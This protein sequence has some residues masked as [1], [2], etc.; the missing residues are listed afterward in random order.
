[1][2]TRACHSDRR[3]LDHQRCH[4]GRTHGQSQHEHQRDERPDT[5]RVEIAQT[6]SAHCHTVSVNASHSPT[7]PY[8]STTTVRPS[9]IAHRGFVSPEAAA[10]GI[11]ENTHTAFAAALAAGADYIESDCRL[12]S[13][14]KVVLFHDDDLLRV[15]RDPRRASDVTFAELTALMRDRGGLL[16]LAEALE[17]FPQARFNIDIKTVPVADEAGRILG[18][19]AERVLINSFADVNR[20]QAM[21][22]ATAVAAMRGTRPPAVGPGQNTIIGILG[23]LTTRSR[24]LMDRAFSGLDAV[25]IPERQGRIPVLSERLISEAHRRGVEVHVWT[26]NE[27]SR[28]RNLAAMGVDGIVTDRSDIAV[29]ALRSCD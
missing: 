8:L 11:A 28:M 26:V 2:R 29:S 27:A 24:R 5:D 15:L 12:T 4:D 3:L 6:E 21:R 9:I 25:Q 19:H 22:V 1:M 7:H 20:Q 23:A 13:D 17:A 14:G 16:G 18:A 10:Q